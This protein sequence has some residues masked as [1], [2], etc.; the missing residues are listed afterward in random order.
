MKESTTQSS[1]AE[2]LR[3]LSD[4]PA[5]LVE[6]AE[7][8]VP[9]SDALRK[10]EALSRWFL[11]PFLVSTIPLSWIIFR[12]FSG[13]F[14]LFLLGWGFGFPLVV[15]YGVIEPRVERMRKEWR[16]SVA[17]VASQLADEEGLYKHKG[18]NQ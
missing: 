7:A 10:G 5:R 9:R 16:I 18:S 1:E 17:K 3:M 4:Y 11:L 15:I 14:W 2:L 13:S 12:E 8:I 6:K